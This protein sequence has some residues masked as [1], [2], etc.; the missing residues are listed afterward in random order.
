MGKR[1]T[2]EEYISELAA[3]NPNVEPV[4]LYVDSNTKILHRCRLCGNEWALKPSHALEGVLC[5]KCASVQRGK[6]RLKTQQQ[7]ILDVEEKNGTVDVIDTYVDSK[8]KINHKC[9]KCE[10]IWL[11]S[12]Y[13]ILQGCGCPMC[14]GGTQ[15]THERYV[16]EVSLLH[17]DIVVVEQYI[18]A[19]TKILH[20]CTNCHY[21]WKITPDQILQG[22][23]CPVCS[24]K[25]IGP[26]P[27]YKNSI[28][29]SK[30]KEY[31]SM[32]LTEEQMKNYMPHSDKWVTVKCWDCEREKTVQIKRLLAHSIGCICGDGI[33]YPNKFVYNVLSQ[34]HLNIQ[35]EWSPAWANKKRYD[36]YL[37]DFN[38][39]IE[40]HGIQHYCDNHTIMGAL[41]QQVQNDK[42][43]YELAMKNGIDLYIV[44]DCRHSNM[45]WIKNSIMTSKLPHLLG[46]NEND[47]DWVKADVYATNN[48]VKM[49]A[50][51][52]NN[53]CDV[54]SIAI[55]LNKSKEAIY[56]WIRKAKQLGW[57]NNTYPITI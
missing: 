52:L 36:D 43:K 38:V 6:Q 31:F 21:E 37:V 30:Y 2:N 13:S 18:N 48:F 25:T 8:T 1:K 53:G 7:Y 12:P 54:K 5:K 11:V 15:K 49:A 26:S 42:Y 24:G 46:F 23:K 44:L 19:R 10:H 29:A 55:T 9:R 17:N 35:P 51:M 22:H 4:E 16:Q 56:K 45:E 20:Q 28:W 32:Y 3:K 33:S 47:I 40:N 34:L 27:E 14:N 41:Q 57:I 39:I 50:E